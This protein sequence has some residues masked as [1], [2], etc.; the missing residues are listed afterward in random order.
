MISGL[1]IAAVG[2]YS[3]AT[4]DR[5]DRFGA[6][7]HG[8]HVYVRSARSISAKLGTV[9]LRRTVE[10]ALRAEG[11]FVASSESAAEMVLEYSER[12]HLIT[13]HGHASD[14]GPWRFEALFTARGDEYLAMIQGESSWLGGAVPLFRREL[15]RMRNGG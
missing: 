4:V 10:R 5:G 9:D 3:T 14:I 11:Y 6:I 12:D 1:L 15:N 8:R 7:V 13:A 2:C